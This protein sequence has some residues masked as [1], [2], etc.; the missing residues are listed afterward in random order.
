MMDLFYSWLDTLRQF[1]LEHHWF[2]PVV[3]VFLP[4]IEA[5]IPSLPLTVLI[6]FNISLLSLSYGI[7]GGT[8]LA[9]VL[10]VFGSFMGMFLI[11]LLIKH[12]FRERFQKKVD[13][14]KYG[15]KFLNIVK[16]KNMWIVLFV[17][18]NPFMPS[19][20]LNYAISL[21]NIRTPKY[22]FLTLTSRIV[23]ILFLVFLGSVFNLQE[24]PLNVV[25]MMLTYFALLGLWF[26]FDKHRENK[27]QKEENGSF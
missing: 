16:G 6:G 3:A 5:L 25:F 12:A 4:F 17:M 2:A 15:R 26:L 24:H 9:I 1:V 18:S 19:S 21:T 11:F 13:D 27:K 7:P 10:S 22:V 8:V 20:I 23:I 14:N